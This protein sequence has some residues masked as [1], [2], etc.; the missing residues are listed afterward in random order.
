[1]ERHVDPVAAKPAAIYAL[2]GSF[3]GGWCW[4]HVRRF[5]SHCKEFISPIRGEY[6]HPQYSYDGWHVRIL[7]AMLATNTFTARQRIQDTACECNCRWP[8][9]Y[10][11]GTFQW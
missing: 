8:Y 1:M 7:Q 5:Q 2:K 11:H 4:V 9:W 6:L 3:Y 10:D